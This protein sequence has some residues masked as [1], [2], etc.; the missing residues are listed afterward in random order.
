MVEVRP[1]RRDGTGIW[2]ILR[3]SASTA[4][5][6]C[7][8]TVTADR[9][10]QETRRRDM[11]KRCYS[12]RGGVVRAVAAGHMQQA[13]W[14]TQAA[15]L[16]R[17]RGGRSEDPWLCHLPV[18][19]RGQERVTSERASAKGRIVGW[20]RVGETVQ[21]AFWRWPSEV[22]STHN[23]GAWVVEGLS[24]QPTRGTRI[25]VGVLSSTHRPPSRTLHRACI[26]E[27]PTWS[28]GQR[29]AKNPS[30]REYELPTRPHSTATQCAPGLSVGRC[31]S[32]ADGR[33]KMTRHQATLRVNP[34]PEAADRVCPMRHQV[35]S[36]MLPLGVDPLSSVQTCW[37][38]GLV[39]GDGK[40]RAHR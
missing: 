7:E 24:G 26:L 34:A 22:P 35:D 28:Q 30:T 21:R 32:I 10:L 14:R 17:S 23:A 8:W 38:S 5:T 29:M 3:W 4:A 25:S 40:D 6:K 18:A 15:Q 2:E 12:L 9:G 13:R 20:P 33:D 39:D 36:S 19:G 31:P 37:R 16:P 11:A 27:G 1:R